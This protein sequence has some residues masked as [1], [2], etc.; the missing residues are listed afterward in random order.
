MTRYFDVHLHLQDTRIGKNWTAHWS[1]AQ[2][3]GVAGAL[4]CGSGPS[5]WQR[6]TEITASGEGLIPAYGVHPWAVHLLQNGW[7]TQLEH[8]LQTGGCALG[9]VGLDGR[10]AKAPMALQMEV[11]TLQLR[12]ADRFHLPVSLHTLDAWDQ[13]TETLQSFP[14][15]RCNL[16]AFNAPERIGRLAE[17]GAYFSFNGDLSRTGTTRMKRALRACPPERLL[18]ETDAP[19]FPLQEDENRDRNRIN[20]PENL[21]K[22]ADLAARTLGLELSVLAERVWN[23]SRVY[24]G[25]LFPGGPVQS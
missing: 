3:A 10:F 22:I 4:C 21:P 9:E 16:H 12:L 7:L 25:E 17:L 15:L 1:Y 5:D 19:D 13:M 8:R 20:L 6:V 11:L 18:L 24:M 14:H 23:N 2:R